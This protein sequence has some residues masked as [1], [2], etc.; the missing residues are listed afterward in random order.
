MNV[1]TSTVWFNGILFVC[2]EVL[3]VR[4][5]NSALRA[6]VGGGRGDH[7]IPLLAPHP[8]I[9]HMMAAFPDQVPDIEGSLQLF[10]DALPARYVL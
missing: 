1:V 10:P 3:P 7:D 5:S 4:D 6:C 8:N 9:V 2:R